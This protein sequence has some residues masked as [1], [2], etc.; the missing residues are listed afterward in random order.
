MNLTKLTL[1][2]TPA[3]LTASCSEET[4][5]TVDSAKKR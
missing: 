2:A 4:K 3:S 5:D 1:L